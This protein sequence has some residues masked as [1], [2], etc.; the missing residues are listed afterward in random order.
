MRSSSH[1]SATFGGDQPISRLT[2]V[3]VYVRFFG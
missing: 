2:A 3:T 1:S